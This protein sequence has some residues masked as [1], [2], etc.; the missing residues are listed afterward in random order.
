M[1]SKIVKV[2]ALE[3][4][5]PRGSKN[6]IFGRVGQ[7]VAAY[8]IVPVLQCCHSRRWLSSCYITS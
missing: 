2:T 1:V 7:K 3:I 8:L 5:D 4:L 6:L